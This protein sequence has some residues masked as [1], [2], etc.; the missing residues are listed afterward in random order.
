MLYVLSGVVNEAESA[1]KYIDTCTSNTS[2]SI[3]KLISRL[4]V[5]IVPGLASRMHVESL[6]KPC[7]VNLMSNDIRLVLYSLCIFY[8]L[9][10]QHSVTIAENAQGYTSAIVHL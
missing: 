1:R 2:E 5:L 4:L 6:G 8:V 3:C 9:L 10:V 7:L